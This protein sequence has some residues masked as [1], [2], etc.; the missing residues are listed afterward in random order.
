MSTKLVFK[1][2]KVRKLA[3]H[4][5]LFVVIRPRQTF[6]P[7]I[8]KSEAFVRRMRVRSEKSLIDDVVSSVTSVL[9]A[10]MNAVRTGRIFVKFGI[11]WA[12]TKIL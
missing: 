6:C 10:C 11:G 5:R 3:R 4:R 9:P 7:C 12:S 1:P 2:G 8:V